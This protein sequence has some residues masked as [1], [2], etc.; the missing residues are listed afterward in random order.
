MLTQSLRR[1][2]KY[3]SRWAL[4]LDADNE[5]NYPQPGTFII[6]LTIKKSPQ[7]VRTLERINLPKRI[8][9]PFRYFLKKCLLLA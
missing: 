1:W 3:T 8:Q 9:D 7:C 4:E 5:Y 2:A 6:S